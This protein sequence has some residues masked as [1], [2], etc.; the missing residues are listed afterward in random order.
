MVLSLLTLRQLLSL[1]ERET[2]HQIRAKTARIPIWR[3]L[4]ETVLLSPSTL[5][6]SNSIS[7]AL[8]KHHSQR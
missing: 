2:F 5:N 7:I 4:Q 1:E 6:L 8:L 3:V